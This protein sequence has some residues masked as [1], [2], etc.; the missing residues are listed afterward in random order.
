MF[1]GNILSISRYFCYICGLIFKTNMKRTIIRTSSFRFR[2]WN[3]KAYAAF[4]SIGRHVTIGLVHKSIADKSLAKQVCVGSTAICNE[5]RI[6]Y[7]KDK[8][9]C[10]D[11]AIS[12][13]A[14]PTDIR[15][16]LMDKSL[17]TDKEV[18][19]RKKDTGVGMACNFIC[20]RQAFPGILP[21]EIPAFFMSI[22]NKT[23]RAL[24]SNFNM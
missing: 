24:I 16:F 6:A 5:N 1:A 20:T 21:P 2:R 22:H 13:E 10:S 12:P 7:Q 3:R 9:C 4:A 15:E 14:Y 17:I 11:E 18:V 19:C 23:S 8:K